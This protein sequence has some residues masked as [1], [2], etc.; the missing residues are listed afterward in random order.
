MTEMVEMATD[1][2]NGEGQW[3]MVQMVVEGRDG[4]DGDRCKKV[5]KRK[6]EEV[7]NNK[8]V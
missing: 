5:E 2:K 3:Q 1:G 8:R 4:R 7:N 6:N